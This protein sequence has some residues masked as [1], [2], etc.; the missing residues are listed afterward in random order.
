MARIFGR[1]ISTDSQGASQIITF[2]IPAVSQTAARARARFN[3]RVKSISNAQV[4]RFEPVR[5]GSLPG[6]RIY[7][8]TIEGQVAR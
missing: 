1:T 5:Q 2:E 8:V 6:Q 4:T 3:A 7:E